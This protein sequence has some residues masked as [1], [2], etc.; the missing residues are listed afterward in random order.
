MVIFIIKRAILAVVTM[1]IVTTITFF[2]MFMVPGGPFL[3][4]RSSQATIDMMNA[5]YGLDQPVYVQYGNYIKNMLKGDLGM[6]YKRTGY[7]VSEIIGEKFPVSARLG[8]TAITLSILIAV[9]LGVLAARRR[10]T[11]VDRLIMAFCT[12]GISF[13]SFVLS[14]ILL[15]LFG[16]YFKL[17]PTIGLSTPLHYVMPVIALS[18]SPTAYITRLTRSN[19]LDVNGMDYLKTARAKGLSEMVVLFKHALRNAILPVVT[20]LGPLIASILTGGF[21]VERI[22]SIPGLGTYFIDSINGRDYPMIMGTTIFFAGLIILS[23]LVVDILYKVI[24]PRI[25]LN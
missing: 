4:E 1:F 5:K 14:T 3:S 16:I 25:K 15:Y 23:N 2:V 20:Y 11:W 7:S 9:P 13:P 24:D 21:V 8:G 6:S 10:N 19:M 17:L 22:F 18:L 12:L